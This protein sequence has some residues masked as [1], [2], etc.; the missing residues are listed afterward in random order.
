[1]L[2]VCTCDPYLNSVNRGCRHCGRSLTALRSL[3][4]SCAI[5]APAAAAPCCLLLG[6][7]P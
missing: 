3:S 4:L 2:V 1:M 5:I 6:S 7:M